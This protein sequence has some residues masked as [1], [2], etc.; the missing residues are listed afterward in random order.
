MD[1][2]HTGDAR[3]AYNQEV[4]CQ[5]ISHA[6]FARGIATG[7]ARRP[8]GPAASS[9]R[10]SS[11]A[12]CSPS[13]VKSPAPAWRPKLLGTYQ[14]L[15]D[16]GVESFFDWLAGGFTVDSEAVRRA[17]DDYRL[18]ASPANLIALQ[19]AVEPP[20]QELFR[21]WNM[22]AGGTVVLVEMRRRLL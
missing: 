6:S 20:R 9:A 15:D 3:A 4:T 17:A 12:R 11:A 14:R 16:E 13:A 21:R 8:K 7:R 18:D 2:R 10:S 19:Q 1:S 22:A 5:S